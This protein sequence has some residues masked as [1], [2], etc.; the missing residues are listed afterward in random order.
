MKRPDVEGIVA[1]AERGDTTVHDALVLAAYVASLESD[2][3]RARRLVEEQQ[4]F[5]DGKIAALQKS[6]D[7]NNVEIARRRE[8]T[9]KLEDALGIKL[10]WWDVPEDLMRGRCPS[11]DCTRER[12]LDPMVTS[13]YCVSE[14]YI[15]SMVVASFTTPDYMQSLRINGED[16]GGFDVRYTEVADPIIAGVLNHVMAR[17][18][19]EGVLIVRDHVWI[20]QHGIPEDPQAM[21]AEAKRNR[22]TVPPSKFSTHAFVSSEHARYERE[23][24]RGQARNRPCACGSGKK[25]KNC[26]GALN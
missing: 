11:G 10:E 25:Y 21:V 26:C 7:L 24:A 19:S 3:N 8:E 17:F 20:R 6:S 4:E 23:A 12:C 22:T 5:I 16:F 18:G 14:T 13:H 15:G 1:R 9:R 2:L